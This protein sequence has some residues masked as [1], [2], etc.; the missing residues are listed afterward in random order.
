ML[1]NLNI[2]LLLN[3]L[4]DIK[5]VGEDKPDDWKIIVIST[6]ISERNKEI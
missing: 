1:R 4:L 5:I 6:N 2:E 3:D